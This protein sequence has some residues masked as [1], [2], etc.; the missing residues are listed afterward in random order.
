MDYDY[1]TWAPA[2]IAD[3][4]RVT[5]QLDAACLDPHLRVLVELRVSHLNGCAFCID[6][7]AM[8][9]QRLGIPEALVVGLSGWHHDGRYDERLRVALA[10]AD[11]LTLPRDAT[12]Y[13][14]AYDALPRCLSADEIVHLTIAIAL[15][16]AWN[17]IAGGLRRQPPLRQPRL[18]AHPSPQAVHDLAPAETQP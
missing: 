5:A 11:A 1:M 3:L 13:E 15:T 17:R 9:A 10:W 8:E 16:Q 7:H 18:V 6:K 14:R 12:A 2:L 4:R